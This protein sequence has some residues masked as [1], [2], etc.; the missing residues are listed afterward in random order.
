MGPSWPVAADI[1]SDGDLDVVSTGQSSNFIVLYMNNGTGA[2]DQG[3]VLSQTEDEPDHLV[4]ADI[5]GDGDLDIVSASFGTGVAWFQNRDG[6]GTFE[7][8]VSLNG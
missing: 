1:D 8:G 4:A 6:E 2:F 3:S 5:D 7:S